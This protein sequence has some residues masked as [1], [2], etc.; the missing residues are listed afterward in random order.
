[1]RES[2]SQYFVGLDIG[3][4][5][6]RCV[7]GTY[8]TASEE[9]VI[10]IVGYGSSPNT[11]MR[12][13]L[14]IHLDDVV[15]S[16]HDALA[17]AERISG[18]QIGS[19]TVNINGS[20]VGSM[21][22]K[23]VI[24]I[25]TASK[26]I[27]TDDK[28]RVQEAATIVQLPSN[29]EIIQVFPKNYQVDGH[30][31]VKDPVG[32]QGVRLE[33]EAHIITAA[34]PNLRS[35]DLALQKSNI[36]PAN[37]TV[38]GLAAA[39]IVLT[40]KQKEAGSAVIDIGAST[41]NIAVIED[42]EIQH[43]GVIPIGGTNITNDLAIGLK[44]DLEIAEKVKLEHAALAEEGKDGRVSVEH[45]K[46]NY[47]FDADDIKMIVE[48]RVE[49]IFEYIDKELKKIHRSQKLPGGVVL[50]GGTAKIPGIAD[51]AKEQLELPA[52]TGTTEK[53]SGIT[54]D[55]QDLRFITAVGLMHLDMIFAY[56][57]YDNGAGTAKTTDMV[58]ST[59]RSLWSKIKP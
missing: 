42:G 43:I 16:I 55:I 22:S 51:F 14:I 10:S 47:V 11:G 20:H 49:E 5:A 4:S 1:M 17:E 18:I 38:S 32:M 33:V 45:E 30:E 54:D 27:T 31:G 46:R 50:V 29:R 13:G 19:A 23:G 41:T 24:A 59:I 6:I 12:K 36:Y 15:A 35:L 52:K 7:I 2:S 48:A 8:D 28:M 3:T 53:L 25:S 44:V 9:P 39:E 57:G 26:Q 40:R 58:G 21:D 34:T 56:H 37:H